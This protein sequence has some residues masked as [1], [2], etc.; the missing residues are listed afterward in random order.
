MKKSLIVMV[1]IFVAV[2]NSNSNSKTEECIAHCNECVE[3]SDTIT[4]M[5]CTKHC[6]ELMEK[7]HGDITCSKLTAPNEGSHSVED[8]INAFHA[9]ISELVKSGDVS[10]IVEALYVDD[11]VYVASGQAPWFGKEDMKQAWIYWF[12]SNPSV[13]GLIYTSTAF[14]ESNGKVWEGGIGNCYHDDVLVGSFQYMYVYKRVNGGLLLS[15]E[16]EWEMD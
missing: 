9:K 7:D 6:E 10:A 13:N 15:I 11:S 16:I 4:H 1:G 14:G 12:E 2:C 8:E 5:G 3:V